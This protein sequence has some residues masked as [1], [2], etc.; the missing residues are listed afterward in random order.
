MSTPAKNRILY[1]CRAHPDVILFYG[2][3]ELEEQKVVSNVEQLR[4]CPKCKRAY[5]PWECDTRDD[6]NKTP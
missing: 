4:Y 6:D 5:H 2:E 3:V 1:F